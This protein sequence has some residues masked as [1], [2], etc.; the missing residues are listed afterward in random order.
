MSEETSS[1]LAADGSYPDD[2][3][4]WPLRAEVTLVFEIQAHHPLG[5]TEAQLCA[6]VSDRIGQVAD[7]GPYP[8]GDDGHDQLFTFGGIGWGKVDWVDGSAPP[9]G[10][11]C[12]Q[13]LEPRQPD[14]PCPK[15]VQIGHRVVPCIL[16]A[17]HH[18]NCR[19]TREGLRGAPRV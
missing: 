11:H 9:L 6:M 15:T 12:S 3:D 16:R 8:T 2:P 13:C 4:S 5:M 14:A 1:D 19:I 18:Q 7:N 17:Q 10:Y